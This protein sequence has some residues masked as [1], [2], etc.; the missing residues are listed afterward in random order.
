MTATP[1]SDKPLNDQKDAGRRNQREQCHRKIVTALL[2][3]PID[4]WAGGNMR[5]AG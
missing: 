1:H 2:R 5:G 4:D 3:I